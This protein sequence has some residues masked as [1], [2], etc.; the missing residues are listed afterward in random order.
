[1]ASISPASAGSTWTLQQPNGQTSARQAFQ[2][3]SSALQS[4]DLSGAQ[5]AYSTLSQAFG[6]NQNSPFAS[7]L[8]QIG[9][10]LQSGDIDGA[11]NT[12][13]QLQQQMQT[14]HAHHHH[15]HGKPDGG[16]QTQSAP[17][18][19]Q[20]SSPLSDGTGSVLNITA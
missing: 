2:Q 12:L 13:S 16:A 17:D 8:Q 6:S 3:L 14:G 10:D 15:H 7:A 1:M 9:S 20:T 5:S 19:S 4:G 18:P 11:K